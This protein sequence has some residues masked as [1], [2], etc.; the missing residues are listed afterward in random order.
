MDP[1]AFDTETALI[2]PGLLAPPLVCISIADGVDVDLVHHTGAREVV[3]AMLES[4][5][6]LVGHNVS[7]DFGVIA[8]AWPDLLPAI[9]DAY[10]SNRVTDT[11]LRE[12][13]QHIAI[14]VYRGFE[15]VDGKYVKLGYSLA[16]VAKRRVGR[17][18]DKD[19][20]RLRYA[21]LYDVPITWWPEGAAEYAKTDAQ[22]TFGVWR[23][24]QDE[25]AEYLDD[26]YRQARA[27]F[28]LHLMACYGLKTDPVAV[29]AHA[30]ALQN[31]YADLKGELIDAGLLRA[32]G[33][34]NTKAAKAYM[35]A[36]CEDLGLAL[37][38]TTKGN[39]QL[40][41]DTCESTGDP[42]LEAYAEISGLKKKLGTDVELLRRGHIQARFESLLETGRT[43]SSPNVQNLPRKGGV[44]ECF[45]PR[46]GWVYAAADYSQFELRTVSQVCLA[47]LGHSQLAGALNKGFDPHL[48]I[49]RRIVGCSYEEA[50]ANKKDPEID[51]ARQVGK[52][53]NFGFPGGLGYVRFVDFARKSYGVTLSEDKARALKRYWFE[54]WPEFKAYFEWIGR[55]CDVPVPVIEQLYVGRKRANVTFTEACNTMFQ[56]LA[57]DA[58]KHA[59]F[60]IAKACYVEP[61]SPLFGSRPA[62][63]VHDEYIVETLDNEGAGGVAAELARLM[64]KGAAPFLPDVPAVVEPYLMR[65][66]SK[67]AGPLFDESGRLIPWD[68][69]NTA[70]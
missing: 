9:F 19:T 20:W 23:D 48:E 30:V 53:A 13:L 7:Y 46:K 60:L 22:V 40:D 33:V 27:A 52:V 63:F 31:R 44:R 58:A 68:T 12:K 55:Q 1:I 4:G 28:M 49:A 36:T 43:S 64:I 51:N 11:M 56:G 57:A 25:G 69:P 5:R 61:A 6:V 50:L 59:G 45:V 39:V 62:N 38:T 14:G 8:A 35:E 47:V 67:N 10:E 37:V 66:W 16:E 32:N 29:E 18:L 26:Q 2:K 15:H 21:E 17:T 41:K 24:Q 42:I 70:A 34:R 3:K 65:R 54:A